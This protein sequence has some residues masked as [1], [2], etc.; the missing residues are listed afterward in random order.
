MS[1]DVTHGAAWSGYP[2]ELGR[3]LER[4]VSYFRFHFIFPYATQQLEA[5]ASE[6]KATSS[7]AQSK[8]SKRIRLP[9]ESTGA[10]AKSNAF[11]AFEIIVLC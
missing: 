6:I 4:R 8:T 2:L 5:D 10:V 7:T 3:F 1:S 11:G 9:F